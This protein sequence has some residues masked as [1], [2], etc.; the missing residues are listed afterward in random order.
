MRDTTTLR[1]LLSGTQIMPTNAFSAAE[2]QYLQTLLPYGVDLGNVLPL[3]LAMATR[4]GL[5]W[6][7]TGTPADVYAGIGYVRS[8][9]CHWVAADKPEGVGLGPFIA[10]LDEERGGIEI[11]KPETQTAMF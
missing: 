5:S 4:R 10:Q 1:L 6:V 7:L 3:V 11:R 2:W 9:W 8:T